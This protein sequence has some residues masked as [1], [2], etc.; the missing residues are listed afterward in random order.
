MVRSQ[1]QSPHEW[2]QDP[3]KIHSRELPH[4]F[5]CVTR[6]HSKKMAI[7]ESGSR[8]LADTISAG[9]LGL[10]FLVYSTVRN[11][12]L[13]FIISHPLYGILLEWSKQTKIS[14]QRFFF[15]TI[16]K[17]VGIRTVSDISALKVENQG[18]M[19]LKCLVKGIFKED[20]FRH[21]PILWKF[22]ENGP[23]QQQKTVN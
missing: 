2:Y 22:L 5:C 16:Y 23:C 12:F 7:C 21:G 1:G 6:R 13:L 19:P 9:I 3:Y 15:Y 8:S 11:K 18:A 14:L 4:P 10:N 20:I 17:G